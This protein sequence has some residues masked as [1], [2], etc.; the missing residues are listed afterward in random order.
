V[1]GL[2]PLHRAIYLRLAP[3]FGAGLFSLLP[4]RNPQSCDRRHTA[5]R[6]HPVDNVGLGEFSPHAPRPCGRRHAWDVP[7]VALPF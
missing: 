2:A 3:H 5:A 7:P 4:L 1:Q 6:R